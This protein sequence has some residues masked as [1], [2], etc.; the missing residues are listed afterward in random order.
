VL[1]G[2]DRVE[3]QLFGELGDAADP[4]GIR[5]LAEVRQDHAEVHDPRLDQAARCP[6]SRG[7]RIDFATISCEFLGYA[8]RV[9]NGIRFGI[10]A[11][12]AAAVVRSLQGELPI[13]LS[14]RGAR[15]AEAARCEARLRTMT[16]E[17]KEALRAEAAELKRMAAEARRKRVESKKKLERALATLRELSGRR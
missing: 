9:R 2:P 11:A 16:P 8:R 14:T 12:G 1:G 15:Y 6:R 10:P 17:E 13:E 3:P 7:F 5:V 4:V